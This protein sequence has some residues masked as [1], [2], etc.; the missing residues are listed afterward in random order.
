[1]SKN[2][3]YSKN[4]ELLGFHDLKDRPGFQMAM[5]VVD[6][7]YY[8][9]VSHF[10]H[11]G[12]TI[13]EV[14]DPEKPRFV[15]FIEGPQLSGQVT[16]KIQVAD[17]LMIG[18][19][20][21]GIPFL[22]KIGWDDPYIAGVH[23]FDVK[24]DPENPKF[25]SFWNAGE[26]KPCDN[27]CLGVHRFFYNGGRY[28]HLSS[29]C[30]GFSNMIYRILDIQDPTNPVEA[31]RWWMPEQWEQGALD[32]DKPP[33]DFPLSMPGMHGPPYVKG[34]YAYCGYNGAGMVILDISNIKLPKL[35]GQLKTYPLLGGK[36]S[37][38]RCHTVVPLSQKPFAIFTNEGE[39]F[40][41]LSKEVIKNQAQ[42]INILGMVDCSDVTDPTL[43]AVFPYPEVPENFPYKNFN[44]CGLGCP[45]PF[46]PH[47]IHEPHDHP[48]LEDCNDR[49]YCCYF[50]AGLRIYDI[51]DPYVPK[52]IAYFIPPNPTKWCFDNTYPGR[53]LAIAED[54]LVDNRGYIF[55]DTFHDGLY[56]L[57]CTV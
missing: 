9:Y 24:E 44:D 6:G 12:W 47:N 45:G 32:K 48:A 5:Q 8:L 51:S 28:V 25:L 56:V 21:T 17:G 13:M 15:R 23:I 20:A 1:M 3:D 50:H 31:G 38:A 4:V 2:K 18:A 57:K 55:M 35:V 36:F 46:G 29:T 10:R 53:P 33:N 19:L 42:P 26:P 43:V 40:P 22:H 54:V 30:D 27:I 49:L 14:T 11:S 37:G 52:E 34:N 39:R 16:N 7:R 41:C